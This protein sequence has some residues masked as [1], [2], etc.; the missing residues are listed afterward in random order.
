MFL[1]AGGAPCQVFCL[2]R[3]GLGLGTDET[4]QQGLALSDFV[5]GASMRCSSTR[6]L[7]RAASSSRRWRAATMSGATMTEW[8][9]GHAVRA[10]YNSPAY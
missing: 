6:R 8:A 4:V 9:L 1:V 10:L 5:E 3:R 2:L 7:S